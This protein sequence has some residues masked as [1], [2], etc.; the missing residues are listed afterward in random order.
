M[1]DPSGDLG[2]LNYDPFTSAQDDVPS[3][4]LLRVRASAD[5]AYAEFATGHRTAVAARDATSDVTLALVRS[6]DHWRI[7]DILNG[8][9]SLVLASILFT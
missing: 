8:Q 7:A 6:A 5:T 4:R 1:N 2:Y 9:Y 3:F